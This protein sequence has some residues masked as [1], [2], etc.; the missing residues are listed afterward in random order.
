[1]E[2]DNLLDVKMHSKHVR[3]A[4]VQMVTMVFAVA[5]GAVLTLFLLW[6]GS[7]LLLNEI[8]FKNPA[9]AIKDIQIQT[10]G[11][12]PVHQIRDWAGVKTGDNLLN[13][14]LL[15]IK[16]DLE[17]SPFI[18]SAVVERVLPGTLKI[19]VTEREPIARISG[20]KANRAGGPLEPTLFY[21]DESGYVLLPMAS[22]ESPGGVIPPPE[23]LPML[24]GISMT[25][26]RPGKQVELPQVQAALR[27]IANF[28]RSPMIDH[29]DLRSI[30]LSAAGVLEV[31]TWQG[32]KVTFAMDSFPTQLRRWRI[33][34]EF[35]ARNGLGVGSLD[36]SVSNNVPAHWLEAS[37][38][39][40]APARMAK[41]S[42][43]RKRHV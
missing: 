22:P 42:P 1:L 39:P 6:Q 23:M 8:V 33:I 43:Y 32:G 11:V 26:L 25:E 41:P 18:Q 17:L 7:D 29:V 9:F 36:L 30:D 2:R 4:R 27:L 3:N 12:V 37:A 28:T 10:D 13:L 19:E 40:A 21:L 34:Q 14:D 38:V 31:S 24:L 35:A 5:A 15:R 20:Y 16:R